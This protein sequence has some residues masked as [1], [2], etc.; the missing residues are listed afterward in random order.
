MTTITTSAQQSAVALFSTVT[1]TA[2]AISNGANAAGNLMAELNARSTDRLK[3][4]NYDLKLNGQTR[5][6]EILILASERQDAIVTKLKESPQLFET[7]Q[8]LLAAN[9]ID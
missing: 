7:Y 2:S 3:N 8:A 6:Q 5:R 1:V 9:P 4:V